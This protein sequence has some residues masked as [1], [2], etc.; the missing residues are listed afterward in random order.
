VPAWVLWLSAAPMRCAYVPCYA[1]R[2]VPRRRDL[3]KRIREPRRATDTATDTVQLHVQVH[4]SSYHSRTNMAEQNDPH[5]RWHLHVHTVNGI[6][7][8]E[9]ARMDSPRPRL[10]NDSCMR[11]A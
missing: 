5:V 4:I 8:D 11:N 10:S 1:L 7:T 6:V 3:G 9:Q 2:P